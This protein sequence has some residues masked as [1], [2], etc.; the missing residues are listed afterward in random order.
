MEE[1]PITLI[2]FKAGPPKKAKR[3]KDVDRKKSNWY[4]SSP[5]PCTAVF[6]IVQFTLYNFFRPQER[7]TW[8]DLEFKDMALP[9]MDQSNNIHDLG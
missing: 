5:V 9:G 8:D 4:W 3:Q 7:S 1:T 2:G 6:G